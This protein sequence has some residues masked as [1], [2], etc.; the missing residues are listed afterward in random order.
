MPSE[1][2]ATYRFRPG[3][4]I[5]V[6]TFSRFP[7]AAS[8]QTDRAWAECD[9][10]WV[11]LGE[12]RPDASGHAR[13]IAEAPALERPPDR[14]VVTGEVGPAGAAPGGKTL[15]SWTADRK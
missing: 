1:A 9:G 3:A 6:L 12:G 15:V 13:L 10:R 11:L 14:L 5:A 8:G 4:P 7:P 2:H